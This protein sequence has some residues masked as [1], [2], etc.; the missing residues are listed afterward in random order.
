MFHHIET[1]QLIC[2]AKQLNGLVPLK[3]SQVNLNEM[4]GVA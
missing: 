3:S 2:R 4:I 1:S